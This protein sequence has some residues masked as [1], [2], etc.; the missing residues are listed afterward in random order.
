MTSG[1]THMQGLQPN[2]SS[3]G[4]DRYS[5]EE[6]ST[7]ALS[8]GVVLGLLLGGDGSVVAVVIASGGGVWSW[9]RSQSVGR[10]IA[11]TGYADCGLTVYREIEPDDWAREL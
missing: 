1:E 5:P 9:G 7:D 4:Y 6:L 8:S 10:P 2:S 11:W 3:S